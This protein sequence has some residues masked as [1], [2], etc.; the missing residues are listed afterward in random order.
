MITST[1]P[2]SETILKEV[3]EIMKNYPEKLVAQSYGDA[4]VMS[5]ETSSV[6]ATVKQRYGNAITFSYA[7]QLNLVM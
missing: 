4:S 3:D 5:G 6:Q 2:L 7:R 1:V